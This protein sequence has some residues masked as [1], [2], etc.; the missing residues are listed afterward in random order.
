MNS[1]FKE[2]E[3]PKTAGSGLQQLGFTIR[4]W[5]SADAGTGISKQLWIND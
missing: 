2:W 5:Q 1:K 3:L 4:L